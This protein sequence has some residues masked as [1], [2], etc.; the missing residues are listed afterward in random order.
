MFL[1]LRYFPRFFFIFLFYLS[2][3]FFFQPLFFLTLIL[4]FTFLLFL[5]Q[6][7]SLPFITPI[8]SILFLP[9]LP[10]LFLGG[11]ARSFFV[12]FHF[13]PCSCVFN[14]PLLPE[15]TLIFP[16]HL[17]KSNQAWNMLITSHHFFASYRLFIAFYTYAN[18][19][20]PTFAPS[21]CSHLRGG[22]K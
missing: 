6:I 13:R 18:T 12:S 19:Y 15:N 5:Q 10:T 14:A 16:S 1:F 17:N 4:Y 11:G 9:K 2:V 7:H 22:T 8:T 3:F 21:F 20:A